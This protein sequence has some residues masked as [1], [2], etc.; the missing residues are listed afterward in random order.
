MVG[1]ILGA[2]VGVV[3]TTPPFLFGPGFPGAIVASSMGLLS[4]K[5]SNPYCV[6]VAAPVNAVV[7]G[8]LGGL[9]SLL[10]GHRRRKVPSIPECVA[11]GFKWP[12]PDRVEC[13][14]CHVQSFGQWCGVTLPTFRCEKCR[15]DLTGNIS[16]VCPE[17]G[18]PI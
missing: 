12:R 3:V 15:Y 11:C 6:W 13:P 7:Y 9:A 1:I 16:G 2:F 5:G 17:C 14:Q 10:I 4:L 18:T 8:V